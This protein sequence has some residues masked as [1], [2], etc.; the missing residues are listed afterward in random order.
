MSKIKDTDYLS[1]SAWLRAMENRLLNRERMERMLEARSDDD[2]VKVLSECGY[3]EMGALSGSALDAL[4]AKARS[5][6]YRQLKDAAPDPRLVEVFQMKYDYHNAK[7]LLKAQAV[8]AQ[9]AGLLMEGGRWSAGAVREAF[10]KDDL[11][12]FTPVFQQAVDQARE[13]LR[14]GGD[15]QQADFALDRAYFEEMRQTAKASE[16][17]F[18]QG[19]VELLTDAVNL[20]SCV[21]AARMGKGGEFLSQVLLPGGSVSVRDL[22]DRKSDLAAL[23]RSTP[24]AD[25]AALGAG[26]SAPGSGELTGFERACDNAVTAYL[27]QAKRTPFGERVVIGYVYARESELTAIRTILSG[28]MAGLSA[29][30]IRERLRE[31]YV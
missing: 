4:T 23:F 22:A 31:A 7:V 13:V 6:L 1:V 11:R 15:P 9:A 10:Q 2:A 28:R 26:L 18:L 20:R 12:E 5:E 8:G 16:S 30:T 3:G 14:A 17:A 24:L 25:A 29:D 21:R 19:Y 27:A